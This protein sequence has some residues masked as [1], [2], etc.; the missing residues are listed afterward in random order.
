MVSKIEWLSDALLSLGA[1]LP[2]ANDSIAVEEAVT[3]LDCVRRASFIGDKALKDKR[4]CVFSREALIPSSAFMYSSKNIHEVH[5]KGPAC[6]NKLG[7]CRLYGGVVVETKRLTFAAAVVHSN[8]RGEDSIIMIAPGV[9]VAALEGEWHDDAH[10]KDS[11]ESHV[12]REEAAEF[13]AMRVEGERATRNNGVDMTPS[14]LLNSKSVMTSRYGV[15]PF[16]SVRTFRNKSER[17]MVEKVVA[18]VLKVV[19]PAEYC[20]S[21]MIEKMRAVLLCTLF[22]SDYTSAA[23]EVVIPEKRWRNDHAVRL[24]GR[25]VITALAM[26]TLQCVSDD[27]RDENGDLLSEFEF[28]VV[29]HRGNDAVVRSVEELERRHISDA[30]SIEGT[31]LKVH[32]ESMFNIADAM[33][34]LGRPY[35]TECVY[36]SDEPNVTD[37]IEA[38]AR[39]LFVSEDVA[40]VMEY[41]RGKGKGL[42]TKSSLSLLGKCLN[43]RQ[44]IVLATRE[45]DGRVSNCGYFGRDKSNEC[46]GIFAFKTLVLRPWAT[47]LIL[48][49]GQVHRLNTRE[50]ES[51]PE[52]LRLPRETLAFGFETA[53]LSSFTEYTA[54]ITELENSIKDISAENRSLKNTLKDL[55]RKVDL[56]V[57][58]KLD[59]D[60]TETPTAPPAPPGDDAVLT[61]K[62]D[63]AEEAATVGLK[64]AR[65]VLESAAKREC[66]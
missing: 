40:K 24:V 8:E 61:A 64:R 25:P 6:L 62:R 45:K 66:V 50:P 60:D 44:V 29:R 1:K 55:V 65:M 10:V 39:T 43:E 2:G 7:D 31:M 32:E 41:I 53:K 18:D 46:I 42:S 22:Q 9:D 20:L 17:A 48:S 38:V 47:L 52:D 15:H 37:C 56:L 11:W 5:K 27:T 30:S 33:S 58:K 4:P 59:N 19:K 54:K 63:S 49:D 12:L 14:V 13:S 26:I 28:G 21:I 51:T 23:P 35:D 16:L 36:A 57:E 34:N 3:S